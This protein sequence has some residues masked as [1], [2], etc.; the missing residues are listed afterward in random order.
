MTVN[1]YDAETCLHWEQLC[2]GCKGNVDLE[3]EFPDLYEERRGP[4]CEK[5]GE[6]LIPDMAG[7]GRWFCWKCDRS[8]PGDGLLDSKYFK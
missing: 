8:Y 7:S 5:D 1:C 6:I 4:A 3:G 2:N